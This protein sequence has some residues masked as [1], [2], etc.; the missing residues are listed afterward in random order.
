MED[1]PARP[2]SFQVLCKILAGTD[3]AKLRMLTESN[4]TQ[5]C[6]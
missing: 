6:R 4:I 3:P 5:T 2:F 1:K